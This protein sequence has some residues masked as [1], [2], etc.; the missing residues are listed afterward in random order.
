MLGVGVLFALVAIVFTGY[1]SDRMLFLDP[2]DDGEG[3]Y[4]NGW[5]LIHSFY[6]FADGG[7]FGV[8]IGNSREKYLWLPEAETDFIFAIIGEELGLVGALAV[9]A[10]FMLLLWAGMRIARSAP[11]NF[12]AM[13]AGSCTIMIVFQ[14]FLNI[15][16]VI[17]LLPTT[18]KPLPFISSGGSSLIATL[19]MVGLVLSVS[20]AAGAPSVY[21]RRRDDLRV[22]RAAPDDDARATGGRRSRPPRHNGR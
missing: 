17:G 8:G 13:V 10:L 14:A 7:L 11:D 1:R 5:Q 15:G 3:G 4:G 20:Q 21:D 22:V 12:G 19:I 2:W 16:C 18:G 6:A 9:V